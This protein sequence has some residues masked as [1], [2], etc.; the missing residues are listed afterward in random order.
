VEAFVYF[1]HYS[2]WDTPWSSNVRPTPAD[3]D[4]QAIADHWAAADREVAV[5]LALALLHDPDVEGGDIDVRVQCGVALLDGRVPAE[6][7]KEAALARARSTEGVRDVC[8]LL[9]VAR[10]R[11]SWW[12]YKP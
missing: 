12:R 11:R 5:R 4:R 1:W 7:V 8:D 10:P 2:Q 3:S 9:T 6:A